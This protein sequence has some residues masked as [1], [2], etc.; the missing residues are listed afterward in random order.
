M[1]YQ[2][3]TLDTIHAKVHAG[4]M[5]LFTTLTTAFTGTTPV[6]IHITTSTKSC[7]LAIKGTSGGDAV[8]SLY[9]AP[10]AS[11]TGW[12]G[13]AQNRNRFSANDNLTSFRTNPT[14]TTAGTLLFS[15]LIP[16][17]I[18]VNSQGSGEE[19]F[20]EIILSTSQTYL[21]RLENLTTTQPAGLEC[22]FYEVAG[23]ETAGGLAA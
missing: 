3:I 15:K 14:I 17:G 1:T 19:P 22:H 20:G 16:G 23:S 5:F 8:F 7:H 9:E 4:K 13:I 18:G 10:V 2:K 11:T 6:D 21:A 12:V